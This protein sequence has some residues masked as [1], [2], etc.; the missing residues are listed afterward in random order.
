MKTVIIDNYDS[1]TYNLAHL[2]KELGTEV[3][4][5]RNDKFELE[6]LEKYDKIILSPGPGI[7]EE[8]GLLLEVIRTYAGRKPILGVCL[9]EQA[10]GQAFGGKLTNLSEVFHGIQTNVK[11]K[12]K[13]Y[14]FSGLPTEIP[15]GRYHSWVVDTEGFPEELV[16]TAISSEGQIMALKHREYDVH[17]IQF[18]PESVLTPDG[19]Q[20]VGNWLKGV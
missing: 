4:V 6:E 13:D 7:P 16:I 20:I 9:G 15:V 12:N 17:G 1:F 5:L 8:A 10:I 2:V 14:I 19:K 18:H 3:D 11:I